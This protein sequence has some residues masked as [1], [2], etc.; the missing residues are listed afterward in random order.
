LSVPAGCLAV[1]E[2][3]GGLAGGLAGGGPRRRLTVRQILVVEYLEVEAAPAALVNVLVELH[4]HGAVALVRDG[5]GQGVE[6]APGGVEVAGGRAGV[7]L[8]C[9]TGGVGGGEGQLGGAAAQAGAV[10]LAQAR[11]PPLPAGHC[12]LPAHLA[13]HPWRRTAC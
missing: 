4:V 12:P 2:P 5:P 7:G 11:P 13:P 3:A 6:V 10:Q 1:G 8:A 9:S